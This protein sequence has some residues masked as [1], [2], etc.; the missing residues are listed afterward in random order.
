M[1]GER[2][3]PFKIKYKG[4]TI[5]QHEGWVY[6]TDI[7]KHEVLRIEAQKLHTRKELQE[8]FDFNRV[9]IENKAVKK[10]YIEGGG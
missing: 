10:V 5:T 4:Y 6:I 1:Q 2:I 8:L 3:C 7:H 9:Y